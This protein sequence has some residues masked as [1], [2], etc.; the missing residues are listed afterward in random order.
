MTAGVLEKCE[1]GRDRPDARAAFEPRRLASNDC[2]LRIPAGWSRRLADLAD[3]DP[4]RL[5]WADSAPMGVASGTTPVRANAAIPLRARNSLQRPETSLSRLFRA[6]NC[7]AEFLSKV[8]ELLL[9]R[10]TGL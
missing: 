5:I 2:Y 7:L 4:G 10:S 9:Q 3:P 8:Q 1:R 6:G